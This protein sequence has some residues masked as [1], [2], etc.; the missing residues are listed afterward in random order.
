[1]AQLQILQP[2]AGNQWLQVLSQTYQHDFYH[3]PDYHKLAESQG[4]GLPRLFVYTEGQYLIALPLLL[5]PVESVNGLEKLGSGCNDA[6]SVY[7]YPGPLASHQLLPSKVLSNF[8]AALCEALQ[9][10]GI[11]TVFSRLNPLIP[12]QLGILSGL[13]NCRYIGPTISIDLTLPVQLQ[14]SQYRKN[15]KITINKLRRAGISCLYDKEKV[16]FE[17]FIKIYYETMERVKAS[18][19]YY[20]DH[21]Y[22]Q[23]LV[24][25]RETSVQLFVTLEGNQVIS[26]GLFT[27]ADGIIQYHLGGTLDE[28][29][30]LSPTK[31]L[32]DEVRLWAYE[33]GLRSFHLGGGNGAQEDSLFQFKAGFSRRQH[34]FYIWTWILFPEIYRQLCAEKANWNTQ[35]RLKLGAINY[36]PEY[37]CP[38]IEV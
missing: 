28:F 17:D 23:Q 18:N 10:L 34:K 37:R 19:Y 31:L 32:F 3:L 5:R 27:V 8:R 30:N 14:R 25:N 33:Q 36:F 7:G 29:L 20:F 22:F 11:I 15:H 24:F 9:E 6:S 16:F 4:E 38:A 35:N 26:G 21:S 13:G 2:E 1:M 12:S